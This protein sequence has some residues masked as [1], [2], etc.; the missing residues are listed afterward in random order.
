MKMLSGWRPRA[1]VSRLSVQATEMMIGGMRLGQSKVFEDVLCEI[2]RWMRWFDALVLSILFAFPLCRHPVIFACYVVVPDPHHH[3]P[4]SQ[5]HFL[6][7]H[8][9][10]HPY[11]E[12]R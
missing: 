3:Q 8:F 10:I 12:S 5:F 9:L 7:S 4:H 2:L 1:V 6:P 11:L